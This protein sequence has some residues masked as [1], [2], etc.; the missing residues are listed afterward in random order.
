MICLLAKV[1]AVVASSEM[2]VS[3]FVVTHSHFVSKNIFTLHAN[4]ETIDNFNFYEDDDIINPS[5]STRAQWD[6]ADDWSNLSVDNVVNTYSPSDLNVMDEAA[7][8]LQQQAEFSN[9]SEWDASDDDSSS[10]ATTSVGR[11]AAAATITDDFVAAAVDTI[12]GNFDYTEP[13]VQLYDTLSSM[14][15]QKESDH[16]ADEISFMIRCN[17]SP[18]QFLIDQGRALPELTDD[19]KY[20]PEFLFEKVTTGSDQFTHLPLQ[21]KMTPFFQRGVRK[22]FDKHSVMK[23]GDESILDREALARWMSTCVNSSLQASKQLTIGAHETGISAILSRYSNTY[24]SGRLTYDEFK[25]LYLEVAW[26][27]VIRDIRENK[28]KYQASGKGQFQIPFF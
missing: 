25:N 18:E 13:G 4:D 23:I 8:I 15:A 11:Q 20:S 7:Q 1:L 22:M 12:V 2:K 6:I 28:A 17:Q 5:V 14:N 21:P 26:S 19:L 24:G 3:A 27:G 10:S 16:E 9:I